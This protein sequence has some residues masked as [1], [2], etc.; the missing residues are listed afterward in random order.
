MPPEPD[1]GTPGKSILQLAQE[2]VEV[3]R[4]EPEGARAME[5][6]YES[7]Y[8][9]AEEPEE[10]E[11]KRPIGFREGQESQT[12]A[13]LEEVANSLQDAHALMQE[14]LEAGEYDMYTEEKLEEISEGSFEMYQTTMHIVQGSMSE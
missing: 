14:V 5:L 1:V 13:M 4:G 8:G 10:E 12:S 6:A 9:A 7:L 11:L 3:L 2:L